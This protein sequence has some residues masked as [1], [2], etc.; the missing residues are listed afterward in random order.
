V[1]VLQGGHMTAPQR[2]A[3]ARG[4][5]PRV[6]TM[7]LEARLG[8]RV[9][10]FEWLEQRLAGM[11]VA[12]R[13]LVAVRPFIGWSA[14]LAVL[15][16]GPVRRADVVYATGED[17]GYPLAILLRVAR[18]RVPRLVVRMEQ[19]IYGRTAWR[20][21]LYTTMARFALVRIDVV[22]TRTRAHARLLQSEVGS[23]PSKVRFTPETTDPG[24]FDPEAPAGVPI[25]G[26]PARP[27]ILS[28]GL[29]QRDYETLTRAAADLPVDVVIAAG[30]PWSNLTF[31][32]PMDH[33][34]ANVTVASF[35][36]P[37]M[38]EL[39]RSAALVVVPVFQTERACG[40]NVVLE[41][42]AMKRP[43]VATRTLGL[44][45]YIDDG[46]TG[47]F[48]E[49]GDVDGLRS[50]VQHLLDHP[51]EARRLAERGYEKVRDQLN[52]DR[53]L[54][55]VE[56]SLADALVGRSSDGR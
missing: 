15:A 12:G 55:I 31:R 25:E 33:P 44:V 47:R 32:S 42:W 10:G 9:L 13:L 16:F 53:Y 24:F 28:A 48:V 34:P 20:R 23:P 38:R 56:E 14:L 7:D 39:Y 29:E 4:A 11:G 30:S 26:I 51:D 41:A 1:I 50:T 45:D 6:D 46:E 52:L 21:R 36:R 27:F 17:V 19:P 40:M 8:A 49:V 37:A 22:L 35:A 18:R 43:V 3:I 2:E 5:S 54:D